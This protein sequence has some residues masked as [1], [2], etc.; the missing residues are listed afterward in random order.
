MTWFVK[1][2]DEFLVMVDED[3]GPVWSLLHDRG[4]QFDERAAAEAVAFLLSGE[5][6]PAHDG[7]GM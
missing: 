1:R 2:D 5:P 3:H 6:S 7:G 4:H